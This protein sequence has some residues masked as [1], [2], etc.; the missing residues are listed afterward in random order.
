VTVS[1]CYNKHIT[2][3]SYNKRSTFYVLPFNRI[4]KLMKLWPWEL[5]WGVVQ[6]G[7]TVMHVGHFSLALSK[8]NSYLQ[9]L[10]QSLW[11]ESGGPTIYCICICCIHHCDYTS[12]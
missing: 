6:P 4:L 5:L 10:E 11:E 9:Y 8:K 1:T 3:T 2:I 7:H 12:H